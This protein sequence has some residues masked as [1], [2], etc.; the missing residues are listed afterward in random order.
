MK[1]SPISN[2]KSQMRK[3][4]GFTL[5]ELS[6]ACVLLAAAMVVAVQLLGWVALG[7]RAAERRQWASQEVANV[8][9]HFTAGG[10][11]NATPEQANTIRLSKPARDVLPDADLFVAVAMPESEPGAKRITVELKWRNHAGE[12]DA[13][14][15]LTAW[16]Y[17]HGG[18]TP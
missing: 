18:A 17:R 7:R 10:W 9:E 4:R 14:V 2:L 11:E 16:M 3:R 1:E 12:F 5:L 15:R 6:V 13:P 8:M